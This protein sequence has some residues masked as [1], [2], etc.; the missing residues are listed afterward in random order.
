MAWTGNQFKTYERAKIEFANL[1]RQQI[2]EVFKENEAILISHRKYLDGW[3]HI[4]GS[5]S[6]FAFVGSAGMIWSHADTFEKVT[7]IVSTAILLF[8]H[9]QDRRRED[10]EAILSALIDISNG[11]E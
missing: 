7:L 8:F 11:K 10:A 4:L 9:W 1:S 2:A 6:L 3:S 5:V